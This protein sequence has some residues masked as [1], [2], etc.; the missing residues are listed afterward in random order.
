MKKDDKK[1]IIAIVVSAILLITAI[2]VPIVVHQKHKKAATGQDKQ[3]VVDMEKQDEADK[4]ALPEDKLEPES[5]TSAVEE[6]KTEDTSEQVSEENTKQDNPQSKPNLPPQE[7]I[8]TQ[9]PQPKPQQKPQSKPKPQAKPEQKPQQKP[10]SK[11]E[12][13]TEPERDA[14]TG[15]I[16]PPPMTRAEVDELIDDMYVYAATIGLR[17]ITKE[18]KDYRE[19]LFGPDCW[20]YRPQAIGR[21]RENA[22]PSLKFNI[23]HVKKELIQ[24]GSKISPE[25]PMP[26]FI[27]AELNPM[28][29]YW[30]F[31]V[32]F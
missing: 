9:K 25:N 2:T 17:K 21:T 30:E 29:H 22:E 14:F 13:E 24:N 15:E 31:F 18:E 27:V 32:K 4:L 12:S 8:E 11:P 16:L 1:I 6:E 20:N 5:S 19:N 10:E 3:N 26:F 7:S 28:H 23:D